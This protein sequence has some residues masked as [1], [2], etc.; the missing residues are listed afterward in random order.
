[1]GSE[2][3]CDTPPH[4]QN[5]GCI[6]PPEVRLS[7]ENA[8]LVM[9]VDMCAQPLQERVGLGKV[10]TTCAFFLK[11]ESNGWETKSIDTHLQPE[12]GNFGHLELNLRIFIVQFRL[13]T[14]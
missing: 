4:F 12:V 8:I 1:M 9:F 3:S 10:L 13:K 11:Q 14:I 6:F 7:Y 5:K 2:N